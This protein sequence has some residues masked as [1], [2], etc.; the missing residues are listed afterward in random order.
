MVNPKCLAVVWDNSCGWLK[1]ATK[2]EDHGLFTTY[3]KTSSSSSTA[4]A[5][6]AG[7]TAGGQQPY[8]G[9]DVPQGTSSAGGSPPAAARAAKPCVSAIYLNIDINLGD[10]SFEAAHE[11]G[12]SQGDI[13]ETFQECCVRCANLPI[14]H[15]WQWNDKTKIC[16]MKG[17]TGWGAMKTKPGDF[18]GAMQG[19]QVP[20]FS[21]SFTLP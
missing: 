4:A 20:G 19:N 13:A 16:W 7:G 1:T 12:S 15:Y 3:I 14:C 2:T 11:L 6:E 18:G 17:A 5:T 21:P 9:G 8:Q 10:L